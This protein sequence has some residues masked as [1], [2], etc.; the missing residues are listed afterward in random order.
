MFEYVII[1][2]VFRVNLCFCKY[3]DSVLTLGH[4]ES[5]ISREAS[6]DI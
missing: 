2:L 1:E 6:V 5:G 3:F 4:Y